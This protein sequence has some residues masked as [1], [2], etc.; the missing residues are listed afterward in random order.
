MI[1]S[2]RVFREMISQLFGLMVS[3]AI[4]NQ[5]GQRWSEESGQW[6]KWIFRLTAANEAA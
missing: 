1:C 3:L 4:G 5:A 2:F 6:D